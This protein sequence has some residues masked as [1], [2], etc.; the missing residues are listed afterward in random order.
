LIAIIPARGGSK[1]IPNKNRKLFIGVPIIERVIKN[2]VNSQLFDQIIVSTD[3]LVISEIAKD[4]GALVPFLRP[5]E[6]SDDF[7]DTISV[8]K[9]ALIE[10]DIL[11]DVIVNCVYPTSIF[12]N[13]EIIS[14]VYES[15]LKNPKNF[16]FIV[17]KFS[18]PIQRAFT[19]DTQCLVSN[20][21]F[22]EIN[23]RT[24][25][26]EPFFYDAGQIYSAFCKVWK[27]EV[28]II[29]KGA[30]GISFLN[31]MFVDIDN[32]VDWARAEEMYHYKIKGE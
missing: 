15:T 24:Q 16:S 17:N 19:L 3:D 23:S 28:Q 12:L 11:D 25:D 14:R 1:R 7:T 21:S 20:F 8:M 5:Q 26:T 29:Q 32:P 2:L 30:V 13:K 10:L 4:A 22:V 27:T 9:H 6:L 31:N 18:H